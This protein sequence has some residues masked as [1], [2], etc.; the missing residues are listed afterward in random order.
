[1]SVAKIDLVTLFVDS[2]IVV[3]LD[4]AA[5]PPRRKLAVD[6]VCFLDDLLRFFPRKAVLCFQLQLLEFAVLLVG[7]QS[8][9]GL[10]VGKL[11]I[12]VQP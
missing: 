6:F 8:F 1:M 9:V 10:P 4:I 12:S 5:S 2:I 7:I 3:D 11:S